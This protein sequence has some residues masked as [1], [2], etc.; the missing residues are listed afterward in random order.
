MFRHL[1]YLTGIAMLLPSIGTA[2]PLTDLLVNSLDGR[3]EIEWSDGFE[4]GRTETL[5]DVVVRLDDGRR[6]DMD[7]LVLDYK[8]TSI[9]ADARNVRLN[10]DDTI[11]LLR[12]DRINFT[13]GRS[14]LEALWAPDQVPNAC[15]VTGPAAQVVVEGFGLMLAA[16]ANS[17]DDDSRIRA[18]RIGAT[19]NNEGSSQACAT[20]LGFT[21]EGYEA[22]MGDGSSTVADTL[23]VTA[24]LPG[25]LAS[26]SAD[27]GQSVSLAISARNATSLIP[28]GA[29]A[30]AI[31]NGVLNADFTALGLV[32]TLTHF[33]R[34]RGQ[35]WHADFWMKL[36]NSLNRARGSLRYDFDGATVR[37]ANVLPPQSATELSDAGLTTIFVDSSGDFDI[38]PGSLDL[39]AELAATGLFSAKL[40]ADLGLDAYPDQAIADQLAAPSLFNVALPI[41]IHKLRYDQRDDGLVDALSEIMGLPVTVRISQVREEMSERNM[42]GSEAYR[43]LATAL[44]TFVAIS[45][46]QPPA[47]LV[48]S[49]IDELNLREA[50]IVGSKA[51]SE[52]PNI[53][54]YQVGV[55]GGQDK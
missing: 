22:K 17:I 51:P 38:S 14:Q 19:F 42:E 18:G 27:P 15:A 43:E 28:G 2:G 31:E 5:E 33:L 4:E 7:R 3:G 25:S 26:L 37:L 1:A 35:E 9:V 36:W 29:T 10:P 44:A 49:V 11:L 52:I 47:R 55:A 21:V 34:Y 45:T 30:W 40:E 50:L 24:L 20:S 13:G 46:R 32:P 16:P 23:A 53:F 39:T 12:A 48:L 41:H 6:I 54:D 8:A